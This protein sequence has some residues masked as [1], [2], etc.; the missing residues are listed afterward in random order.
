MRCRP[1]VRPAAHLA[2]PVLLAVAA[3][4]GSSASAAPQR[5]Q[6]DPDHTYPSF[7][8]DHMGLS[9]WRGKFRRS[10]GE[11]WLDRAAGTGRV[12]LTVHT[13][14]V[15]FGHPQMNAVAQGPELLD[16]E[17]HAWARYEGELVDWQDGRPT[18]VAGQFTLR[19]ITRPLTLTVL[20]F[21]CRPHPLWR[22]EVCGA[23]ALATFQ[24]DDY[25]ID[26]GRSLGFDMAVQLRIQVEALAER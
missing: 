1:A 4:A 25:G 26:F 24:R 12:D 23:D 14:S 17:R 19:G 8:A 5:F 15:D 10:A 16:T 7:E 11:V 22:R 21:A 3:W 13:D 18:R 9:V 6:I 2:L 20:R